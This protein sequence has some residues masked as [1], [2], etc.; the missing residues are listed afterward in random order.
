MNK[1]SLLAG[2]A[3][4]AVLTA[5]VAQLQAQAPALATTT[6]PAVFVITE[7]TFIDEKKYMDEFAG[8]AV[9]TIKAA[10]GRFIVRAN[11]VTKLSGDAPNSLVIPGWESLD[12]MKR[13]QA[14]EYAKLIQIRDQ[15]AKVRSFA[16]P[17]AATIVPRSGYSAWKA[18]FTFPVGQSQPEADPDQDGQANL[19]EWL[20]GTDPL[21][22]GPDSGKTLAAQRLTA[23]QVGLTGD[24]TYLGLTTRIRKDRPATTL[25]PE[26]AATP[27]GL[28]A[29][30]AATQ[31][32][33]AGP[34]VDDADFEIITWYYTVPIED[35][36]N[37]FIRLRVIQN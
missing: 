4:G 34:P 13:W 27:D 25:I 10:G 2:I 12:D 18:G 31:V 35:G 7:Q 36:A 26:A 14:G 1:L 15:Y 24:K 29:A 22:L 21:V 17:P 3:I 37:G 11:E 23:E 33:Q 32:L 5:G 19:I 6:R 28:A 30:Q 8:K 16:V 20:L 9:E